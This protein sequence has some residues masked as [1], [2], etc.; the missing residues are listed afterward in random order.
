MD[1]FGRANTDF[2]ASF[3]GHGK[4]VRA[5]AI[6]SAALSPTH[7]SRIVSRRTLVPLLNSLSRISILL[8]L[9]LKSR[10]SNRSHRQ[11]DVNIY[12]TDGRGMVAGSKAGVGGEEEEE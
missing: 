4:R 8:P 11:S 6:V 5:S 10:E 7:A 9:L 2:F 3:R 1:A 12:F